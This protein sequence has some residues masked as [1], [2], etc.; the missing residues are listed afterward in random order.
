MKR[1][2]ITMSRASQDAQKEPKPRSWFTIAWVVAVF[3]AVGA[4]ATGVTK[5]SDAYDAVASKFQ[6][7]GVCARM[8][9]YPIGTWYLISIGGHT[10]PADQYLT[11]SRY[12]T[13]T[14]GVW[15]SG[16]GTKGPDGKYLDY[17]QSPFTLLFAGFQTGRIHR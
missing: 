15:F 10:T 8:Q 4:V 3:G 5:L 7:T 2:N 1:S 16:L 9:D 12:V 14:S 11:E 13:P 17:I 6:R